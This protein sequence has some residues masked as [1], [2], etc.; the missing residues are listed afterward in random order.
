MAG[1]E[2]RLTHLLWCQQPYGVIRSR[3]GIL[4]IEE[5]QNGDRFLPENWYGEPEFPPDICPRCLTEYREARGSAARMKLIEDL[6][7]RSVILT[8]LGFPDEAAD[9]RRWIN[10]LREM[11]GM[12]ILT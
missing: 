4:G 7:Q 11:F 2:P 3:C 12:E 8:G 5:W 6:V 10:R 9:L 1:T